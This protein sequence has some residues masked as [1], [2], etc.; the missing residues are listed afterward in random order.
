[1]FENLVSQ[2]W[3]MKEIE[4]NLVIFFNLLGALLLGILLGAERAYQGRAAGMRTYGLVCMASCALTVFTGYSHFWFGGNV[5]P[6]LVTDPTRV[7][8]G[9]VTG[10]GFLGAGVIMKDGLFSISGLST[11]ASIWVCS[12]IGVLIGVGFYGA[13]I[14]LTFLAVLA[15]FLIPKIETKLPQ[16]HAVVIQLI[17]KEGFNPNE[18]LITNQF[19]K[20]GYVI[21]KNGISINLN[22]GRQE[23]QYIALAIPGKES[24]SLVD[25]S[26]KL[27]EIK[28][29]IGFTISPSRH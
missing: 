23:W 9:I 21:P 28:E 25:L 29:I 2:Y 10:I 12:A 26:K 24:C 13:G 5:S 17:F 16:K 6:N 3:S 18:Q 27:T 7:I 15:M 8:Q 4:I 22:N 1:M 19:F 20:D 14:M 11:A